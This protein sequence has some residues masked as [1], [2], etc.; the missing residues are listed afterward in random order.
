[1]KT[2]LTLL[3]AAAMALTLPA[4]KT[5][6][7][8]SGARKGVPNEFNILTKAPLVVPPEY[9]L[10]PPAS[11]QSRPEDS[12]TSKVAREAL[13]GEIDDAKPSRGEILLMTKAGVGKANPEVRIVIDGQNS[14]EHKSDPFTDRLIFWRDG[15]AVDGQGNPLN[16]DSEA[17]RLQ[18]IQT[19]T[20][21][22]KVTISKR[23]TSGK[24]PGL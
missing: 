21:G 11:G 10:R 4:C 1:M 20:G 22:A 16:S 12:Y 14:V 19:A 18:A 9:N 5:L 15:R 23:P 13:L 7:K 3:T 8:A 17:R 24:L 6:N 2:T